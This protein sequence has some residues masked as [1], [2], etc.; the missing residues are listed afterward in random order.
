MLLI[1]LS[2]ALVSVLCLFS[3]LYHYSCRFFIYHDIDSCRSFLLLE[4]IFSLYYPLLSLEGERVT[5]ITVI[6][7]ERAITLDIAIQR[8]PCSIHIEA[9]RSRSIAKL[10]FFLAILG[11]TNIFFNNCMFVVFRS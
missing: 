8:N 9:K 4:L 10:I 3:W 1:K 7:V 11:G 5:T 6:L 2:S